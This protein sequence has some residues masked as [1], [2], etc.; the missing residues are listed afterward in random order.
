MYTRNNLQ[1]NNVEIRDSTK[2]LPDR[3][4]THVERIRAARNAPDLT[5][6]QVSAHLRQLDILARGCTKAEVQAWLNEAVFPKVSDE[7]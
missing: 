4:V 6:A 1:T 3:I 2:R 7:A 5:K